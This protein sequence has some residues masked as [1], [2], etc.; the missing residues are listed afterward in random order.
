MRV[1]LAGTPNWMG[2]SS[3]SEIA[4]YEEKQAKSHPSHEV[5]YGIVL[6]ATPEPD[7]GEADAWWACPH[8]VH[9]CHGALFI[10]NTAV[11]RRF[12]GLP[13]LDRWEK[14]P[15]ADDLTRVLH[16]AQLTPELGNVEV[17][18]VGEQASWPTWMAEKLLLR[19]SIPFDC[20]VVGGLADLGAK[21]T[22]KLLPQH[23]PG[24]SR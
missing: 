4:R 17:A 21:V 18:H 9:P 20:P 3:C 10:M 7:R 23:L 24:D 1:R 5:F 2:D 12:D 6:L 19:V 8:D 11:R 16:P 22:L 15:D 13:S 14:L